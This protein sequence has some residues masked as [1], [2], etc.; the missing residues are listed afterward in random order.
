MFAVIIGLELVAVKMGVLVKIGVSEA[1]RVGE[2]RGVLVASTTTTS[3]PG[4]L[5][6][7]PAVGAALVN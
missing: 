5:V 6:G 7:G 4:V 1:G 2:I 3:T